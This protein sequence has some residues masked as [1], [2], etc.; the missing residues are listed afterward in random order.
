M[1]LKKMFKVSQTISTILN[2]FV[3]EVIDASGYCLISYRLYKDI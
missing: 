2:D 3:R 1:Y